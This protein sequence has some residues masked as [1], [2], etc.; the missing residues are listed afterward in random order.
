M[1]MLYFTSGIYEF[2]MK[3]W[4]GIVIY[5]QKNGG[6][7]NMGWK[8]RLRRICLECSKLLKAECFVWNILY[9]FSGPCLYT[10]NKLY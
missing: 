1:S 2:C 10:E 9:R 5:T 6:T 8:V 3:S 7:A 4:P